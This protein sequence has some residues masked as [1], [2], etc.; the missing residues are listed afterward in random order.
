MA[1]SHPVVLQPQEFTVAHLDP[2]Q[3]G[4]HRGHSNPEKQFS[5]N[6]PLEA[7]TGIDDQLRELLADTETLEALRGLPPEVLMNGMLES[8][9]IKLYWSPS[10][11]APKLLYAG[12]LVAERC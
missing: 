4:Q 9:L 5:D 10:R 3:A 12:L 2:T 8:L 6:D 11:F 7:N 1:F